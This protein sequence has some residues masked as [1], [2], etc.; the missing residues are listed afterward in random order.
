MF[1]DRPF[2]ICKKMV[3]KK[4]DELLTIYLLNNSKNKYSK[5]SMDDL[6]SYKKS[7]D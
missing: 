2:F 4:L 3:D 7:L 1:Q 6:H 5:F